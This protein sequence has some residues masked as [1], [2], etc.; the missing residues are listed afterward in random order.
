MA[1]NCEDHDDF[2][3]VEKYIRVIWKSRHSSNV[4]KTT[5]TTI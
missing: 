2:S 3:D 4:F 5:L 1:K